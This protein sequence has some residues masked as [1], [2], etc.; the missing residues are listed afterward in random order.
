MDDD[1]KNTFVVLT[2]DNNR[3]RRNS[4]LIQNHEPSSLRK[5][6]SEV[7]NLRFYSISFNVITD[8]DINFYYLDYY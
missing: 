3:R 4:K 5:I 2:Y 7:L 1:N 8:K 6:N